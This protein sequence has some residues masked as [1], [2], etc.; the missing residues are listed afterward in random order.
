M[1]WRNIDIDFRIT[2]DFRMRGQSSRAPTSHLP[3]NCFDARDSA[4]R[5]IGD[6]DDRC[7]PP[8]R[9]RTVTTLL[10]KPAE[11]ADAGPRGPGAAMTRAGPHAKKEIRS[12]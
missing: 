8:V 3:R 9:A 6:R 4:D 5:A 10:A 2:R 11:H 7:R 12:D 1:P